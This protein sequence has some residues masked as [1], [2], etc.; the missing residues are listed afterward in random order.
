MADSGRRILVSAEL[1]P[2]VLLKVLEAK[3][4][5]AQGKAH[6]A[7]EAAR[8][9]GISRSAFYKYKDGV[10]FYSDERAVKIVTYSLTL[11]DEPG[12]LS[13]VLDQISG[14][15]ANILT[16]NQNIPVD[17][18]APVTISFSAGAL[19]VPEAELLDALSSLRGVVG[20]RSLRDNP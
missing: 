12:V 8:V 11:M 7:S 18:V 1:L 4:L 16:I 19:K 9:A 20:C 13:A 14:S 17:G 15:G 6:N 5:L 2:E 3:R 10:A